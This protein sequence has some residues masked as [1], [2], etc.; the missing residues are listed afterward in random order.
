MDAALKLIMYIKKAPG[1]GLVFPS[2]LNLEPMA[3][4]N[5]DYGSCLMGRRFLIGYCVNL[6]R[7]II[8]WRTKK[9]VLQKQN[10]GPQGLRYVKL[11]SS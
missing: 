1:L 10:V 3:F 6:G 7:L 9:D 4:Y 5:L 8:L 2:S 11:C